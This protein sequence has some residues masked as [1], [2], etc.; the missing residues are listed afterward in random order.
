MTAL[1]GW[2]DVETARSYERF[3]K[4]H[5]RY[6]LA[7]EAL[8]ANTALKLGLRVLDLSAGTGR[9]AEALLPGIGVDGRIVCVE[10]ADAMRAIGIARVRDRRVT[11]AAALGDAAGPF[12]RIVCGAAIWQLLPL[13][14]TIAR[15]AAMLAPR[16]ALVFN[17]PALYLREP[18]RPGGGRDPHLL[19][20]ASLIERSPAAN[21][22]LDVADERGLP[23]SADA[24]D[25]IL[26]RNALRPERWSFELRFTQAAYRDWLKIPPTSDG[27]LSGL[28][29][30]ERARRIERAYGLA[31]ARSWR[32]ERW[33]GWTAWRTS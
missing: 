10:Q 18:D 16:G 33:L 17:V 2:N 24:L 4:R 26:V 31:D 13:D 3:C 27:M 29:A 12:D 7:N 9:T 1:A 20:L 6:R 21:E 14:Q 32:W 28:S 15:L 19:A 5:R 11:W 30:G 22:R 23:D 25:A 8:A